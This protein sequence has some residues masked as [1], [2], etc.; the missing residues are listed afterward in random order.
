MNLTHLIKFCCSC[1]IMTVLQIILVTHDVH[2]LTWLDLVAPD[3]DMIYC[4]HQIDNFTVSPDGNRLA[5]YNRSV[6]VIQIFTLSDYSLI[7]T[8][9]IPQDYLTSMIFS[10]DSEQIVWGSSDEG[11]DGHY[12]N[13]S[14]YLYDIG[15][16]SIVKTIRNVADVVD[17]ISFLEHPENL[18]L[19]GLYL[20]Y[21]RENIQIWN[22]ETQELVSKKEAWHI[23]AT[24]PMRGGLL[25]I[26]TISSLGI[27]NEFSYQLQIW[28]VFRDEV[29]GR[30][31]I[32]SPITALATRADSILLASGNAEGYVT[33]WEKDTLI[34][35]SSFLSG[36]SNI[37]DLTFIE[38][39][40]LIIIGED[41]TSQSLIS[42]WNVETEQPQ[43]L[44]D[45]ILAHTQI[46][47]HPSQP[48]IFILQENEG[49]TQLMLWDYELDTLTII[50]PQ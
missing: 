26:G 30:T 10:P 35:L 47:V 49:I 14:V 28:D 42:I 45:E 2:S 13:G 15:S 4:N 6:N 25:F 40:I 7:D 5:I 46:N 23:V 50:S 17:H 19:R 31:E 32:H 16:Q 3:A 21:E 9:Q 39:H 43:F 37:T 1:L 29:I 18:V 41:I 20:G 38:P 12:F 11:I 34:E 24:Y 44:V 27:T 33:I 36:V 22:I 48:A 8:I